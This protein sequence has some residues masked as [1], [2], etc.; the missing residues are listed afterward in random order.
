MKK[1]KKQ[2]YDKIQRYV[3]HLKF[4]DVD[5][6]E[7]DLFHRVGE[8]KKIKQ[9]VLKLTK[10]MQLLNYLMNDGFKDII[11]KMK[12]I[13][14]NKI[15]KETIYKISKRIINFKNKEHFKIKKNMEKQLEFDKKKKE[16]NRR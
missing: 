16:I 10:H 2:K 8:E 12:K 1:K 4:I 6:E 3:E 13:E 11:N 15:D 5:D 9:N 14:I 7:P